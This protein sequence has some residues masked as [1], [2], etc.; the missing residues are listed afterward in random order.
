MRLSERLD[1]LMVDWL[2]RQRWFA[3][4]DREIDEISVLID[5]ELVVGD[6]ALHHVIIAVRQGGSTDRYRPGNSC[7]AMSRA[8]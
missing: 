5:T 7:S 4:K 6:P 2:P 1:D 8:A 3:G